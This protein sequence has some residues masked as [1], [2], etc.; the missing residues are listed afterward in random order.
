MGGHLKE[1]GTYVGILL[2]F[3]LGTTLP[4]TLQIPIIMVDL[5]LL[6][7]EWTILFQKQ[8]HYCPIISHNLTFTYLVLVSKPHNSLKYPKKRGF[9]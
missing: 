5:K 2:I 6:G 8:I 1:A 9:F 3:F 7:L 4:L